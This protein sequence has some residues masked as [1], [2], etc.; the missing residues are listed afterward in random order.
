MKKAL[1]AG[2]A[3]I[4]LA[5][6]SIVTPAVA[7]SHNYR[8]Q[9]RV[10]SNYCDRHPGDHDCWDWNHHRDHWNE[11]RYHDWYGRHRH[12]FGPADAAATLFGF[13]AGAAAG[14]ISGGVNGATTESHR[15]ACDA[16]YRSYDWRTDTFMG[17]DGQRHYCRL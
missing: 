5:T 2:V 9:E 7:D 17:Y 10:M 1:G 16:R 15:A 8:Q 4:V 12:D 3:C 6:S 13:V 11:S 14:A